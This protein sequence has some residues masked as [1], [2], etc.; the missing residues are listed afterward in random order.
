TIELYGAEGDEGRLKDMVARL[1]ARPP[2]V[3]VAITSPAALALKRAGATTPVVFVFVTDPVELGIVKSLARPGGNFTGITY[4]DASLGGKRLDLLVDTLP[5]IT[6]V[7]VILRSRGFAENT[8]IL[9]SIRSSAAARGVR[10]V[11]RELR[12]PE[13]LTS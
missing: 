10:L 3:I 12:D 7:A 11:V 9:A 5:G 4:S 8:A 13:D 1:V 2:D 6:T